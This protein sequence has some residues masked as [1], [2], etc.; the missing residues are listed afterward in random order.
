MNQIEFNSLN[1]I[2][3]CRYQFE[4]LNSNGQSKLNVTEC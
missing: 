1:I 4:M 2:F 3:D